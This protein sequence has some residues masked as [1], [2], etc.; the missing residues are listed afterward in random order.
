MDPNGSLQ[1]HIVS[2]SLDKCLFSI[3]HMLGLFVG[4]RVQRSFFTGI[5][6]GRRDDPVQMLLSGNSLLLRNCHYGLSQLALC[7]LYSKWEPD[8]VPP[9]FAEGGR[10]GSISQNITFFFLDHLIFL[11]R[12]KS[13][14]FIEDYILW[15]RT[16]PLILIGSF[17]WRLR[18]DCE[19]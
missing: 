10:T 6:L 16:A 19:K 17:S 2:S 5:K 14:G 11:G 9:M 15:W 3:Q 13:F 8:T 7:T 1:S 4:I 18:G 12:E